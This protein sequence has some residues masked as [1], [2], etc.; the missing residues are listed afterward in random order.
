[1]TL[2]QAAK[3]TWTSS[4][5]ENDKKNSFFSFYFCFYFNDI[6]RQQTSSNVSATLSD[7]CAIKC[8]LWFSFQNYDNFFRFRWQLFKKLKIYFRACSCLSSCL[9]HSRN[10]LITW[11]HRLLLYGSSVLLSR[12]C[13]MIWCKTE[14]SY[15]AQLIHWNKSQELKMRTKRGKHDPHVLVFEA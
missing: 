2:A 9:T 11:S 12:V 13:H 5:N 1:M 4:I 7:L 3:Q 10:P 6:S 8:C 14:D 15:L